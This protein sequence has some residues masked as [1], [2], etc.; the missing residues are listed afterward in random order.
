MRDRAGELAR[1]GGQA[2]AAEQVDV[3]RERDQKA[4]AARKAA[5][6]EPEPRRELGDSRARRVGRRQRPPVLVELGIALVRE[7]QQPE[8]LVEH[9]RLDR[10][11][12]VERQ[13]ERV[14]Q[15]VERV[16]LFRFH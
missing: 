13:P 8:H 12:L 4:L 2:A 10:H 9:R 3:V 1:R 15:R 16:P 14:E 11:R 5:P 6:L 7:R